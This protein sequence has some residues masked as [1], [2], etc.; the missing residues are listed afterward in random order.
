MRVLVSGSRRVTQ[1]DQKAVLAI[2]GELWPLFWD[3]SSADSPRGVLIHGAARGVDS[4]AADIAQGFGWEIEEYPA[5][6]RNGPRGGP[7][8]NQRMIDEGKP[9][10]VLAFPC[11]RSRGTRDLI[12]RAQSA[13]I[14]T[15]VV[16]LGELGG[17]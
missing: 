3:N 14:E 9:D 4:V 7:D 6:W 5:D 8:R 15:R 10:L 12:R 13:G 11:S 2:G 1:K 17:A 16:E